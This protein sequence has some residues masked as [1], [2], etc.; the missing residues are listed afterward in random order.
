[1]GTWPA[2]EARGWAETGRTV[3]HLTCC[4]SLKAAQGLGAILGAAVHP[5]AV[6]AQPWSRVLWGHSR[7]DK[8]TAVPGQAVGGQSAVEQSLLLCHWH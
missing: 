1:M 8:T 6:L 5:Q 3:E 4:T 7:V 2:S